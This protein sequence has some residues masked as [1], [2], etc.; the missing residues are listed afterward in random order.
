ML[1]VSWG[2]GEDAVNP[3]YN[4]DDED[5]EDDKNIPDY[6]KNDENYDRKYGEKYSVS[7]KDAE[8]NEKDAAILEKI[9]KKEKKIQNMQ[10]EI[11]RIYLKEKVQDDG[12]T[13]GQVATVN[14][15]DKAIASHMEEIEVLVGQIREKN[16][17]RE[18]KQ[19]AQGV[20]GMICTIILYII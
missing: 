15:N 10:E 2:F 9:R 16:A 1:G 13:E 17:Q 18:G 6:L 5:D 7:L 12:L 3:E 14:R 11:K 20:S 8:V 4:D 19:I